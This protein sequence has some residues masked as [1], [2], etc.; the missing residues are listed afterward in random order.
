LHIT[1]QRRGGY[2]TSEDRGIGTD[3]GC[4]RDKNSEGLSRVNGGR[5][6]KEKWERKKC[7][8]GPAKKKRILLDYG[9]SQSRGKRPIFPFKEY[10]PLQFCSSGGMGKSHTRTG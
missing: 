7:R 6:Q 5:P 2:R 8:P 1:M 4:G 10:G 3:T 9:P